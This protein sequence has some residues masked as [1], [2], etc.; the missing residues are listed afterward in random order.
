LKLSVESLIT[1]NTL[2][3]YDTITTEQGKSSGDTSHLYS[4]GVWLRSR[5]SGF[6]VR[7]VLYWLLSSMFLMVFNLVSFAFLVTGYV[8]NQFSR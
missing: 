4:R 8:F 6:S 2:L 5:P 1:D 7:S 3:L